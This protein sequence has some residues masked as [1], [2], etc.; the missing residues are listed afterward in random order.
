LTALATAAWLGHWWVTLPRTPHE[1]FA[2]RCASC[3][4]LRTERV[5]EFAPELRPVIV[6]TM[7]RLHGADAVIDEAEAKIIAAFL[8]DPALCN[9][10][11]ISQ[12]AGSAGEARR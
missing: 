9:S 4:E 2:T 6:D 3:H 8:G 11:A 1:L 5:C 10:M 12:P 7:R